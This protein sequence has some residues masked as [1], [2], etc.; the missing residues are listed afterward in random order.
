M[1]D[2]ELGE[3]SKEHSSGEGELS[4]RPA[5]ETYPMPEGGYVCFHC[6]ER[7]TTVGQAED[8]FGATQGA[9]A[10]CQ[11][12]V[13][14]ERGLLME[15]RK[16]EKSRDEW[17]QRALHDEQEIEHLECKVQSVTTAMQSYKP[18]REC[19]SINDVFFLFD[20]MEGR[21][22]AAEEQLQQFSMYDDSKPVLA[23][24]SSI[25][26]DLDA[27]DNQRCAA[28]MGIGAITKLNAP[29]RDAE[30]ITQG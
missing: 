12:K 2:Q 28:R 16:A 10:G 24:L 20:S 30:T 25:A 23:A 19:R 13:G 14:E 9:L 7:L 18:F 21:A 4:P 17:M 15:L 8:H 22:I 6:G 29:E 27:T 26:N 5:L 11:I 3:G 1:D